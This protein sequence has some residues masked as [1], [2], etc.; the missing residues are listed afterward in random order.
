MSIGWLWVPTGEMNE[1]VCVEP[2]F[3][4]NVVVLASGPGC[5][6]DSLR[7][8]GDLMGFSVLQEW[9]EESVKSPHPMRN[10]GVRS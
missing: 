4:S 2:L 9:E 10:H 7:G 1:F 3:L 5:I 8:S 6:Y